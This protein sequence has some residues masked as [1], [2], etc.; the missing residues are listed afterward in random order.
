MTRLRAARWWPRAGRRLGCL[1]LAITAG[2]PTE[3][4]AASWTP[5]ADSD[6]LSAPYAEPVSARQAELAGLVQGVRDVLKDVPALAG[7][8]DSA[9]PDIC[10]SGSLVLEKGYLDPSQNRIVLADDMDEA[11]TLVVLVHE[12][13]HVEQTARGLCPSDTLSMRSF[14]RAT[15]ALEA[16]AST[17]VLLVAWQRRE[18]GDGRMWAALESWPMTS[19]IAARFAASMAENGD[20]P[21][22]AAAAFDQWYASDDR[23]ERYYI[24]SC[25]D[26]LDRQDAGHALPE[27]RPLMADHFERLCI[28]PDG[29]GYPCAERPASVR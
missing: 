27:Y 10:M 29:T 16:D 28:L 3:V 24:A 8:L 2:F 15:L 4:A 12:L 21:T 5:V 18:I 19:D 11:L 6:C 1:S 14:A 20:V 17:V 23:R 7:V 25:S 26:Y 22:A 13:R 9:A